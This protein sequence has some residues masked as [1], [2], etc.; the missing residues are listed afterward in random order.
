MDEIE[1]EV[2]DARAA[3]DDEDEEEVDVSVC[4]VFTTDDDPDHE[5]LPRR[6]R[7]GVRVDADAAEEASDAHAGGRRQPWGCA[8]ASPSRAWDSAAPRATSSPWNACRCDTLPRPQRLPS[9]RPFATRAVSRSPPA[10][11][12]PDIDPSSSARSRVI[13]KPPTTSHPALFPP[14][15]PPP[16]DQVVLRVRPTEPD[17]DTASAAVGQQSSRSRSGVS[18]S[19]PAPPRAAAPANFVAPGDCVQVVG[20]CSVAITAPEGSQAH[21]T[22]E[23]GGTYALTRACGP[24]TT[25]ANFTRA[26]PRR[27]SAR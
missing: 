4:P 16:P 14:L 3:S 13:P 20:A 25:Q 27:S 21:K 9:R 26:P 11:P 19:Q 22:G 2:A 23:R 17:H 7:R 8:S 1:V 10:P 24:A 18:G 6:I 5:D 15:D 12:A